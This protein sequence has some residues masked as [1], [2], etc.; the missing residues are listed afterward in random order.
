MGDPVA[1][2]VVPSLAR[3]GANLT[4][5]TRMI[6]EMSAKHVELLKRAVPSLR[7]LTVLWNPTNSSH[8]PTMQA[9]EATASALS[10]QVQVAGSGRRRA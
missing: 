8:Q 3:P 5:T 10:L 9:V 6:P 1:S 2:G 4:G 7:K